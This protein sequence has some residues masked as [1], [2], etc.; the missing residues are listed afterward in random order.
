MIAVVNRKDQYHKEAARLADLY[1]GQMLVT[2]EAVLLEIANALAKNYKQAA[3]EV[4]GDFLES[5]EV[6]VV[7]LDAGL[8]ERGFEM[9]RKYDDKTWGLTDC[10]SF[11]VMRER[12]V[13]DALTADN[14]FRQAGFNPLLASS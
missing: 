9:Y 3:A 1:E 11:V 13:V 4:V 7:R 12:G 5:D 14:D 8:F 2:T 10:I 6:F